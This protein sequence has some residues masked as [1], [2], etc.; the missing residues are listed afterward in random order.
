MPRKAK[1]TAEDYTRDE[2][3]ARAER[4]GIKYRSRMNKDQLFK[5]LGLGKTKKK[6]AAKK[7]A[8]KKKAAAVKTKA[9]KRKSTA[10]KPAKKATVKSTKRA[11]VRKAVT[12]K[13]AAPAKSKAPARKKAP[14]KA[15]VKATAERRAP[16]ASAKP[17]ATAKKRAK[18]AA[19]LEPVSAEPKSLPSSSV[20]P[21]PAMQAAAAAYVDRGPKLPD[22]YGDDRV[23]ALVRDPR[24]IFTYWELGGGGYE[25]ARD[26]LGSDMAGA[27]WVLRL[28]KVVGERFFD[29]PIDPATGNWYLHVEPSERYQ[30]KI[31]IVLPSGVFRELAASTEIVTP[32]ERVSDVVDEE[33]MLVREEFDRLIEQI[34]SVRA[35]GG[36]GSSEILHRLSNIPRRM[37]LFSGSIT[38]PRGGR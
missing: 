10:K 9:A 20:V 34:L 15:K 22:G 26:E 13:K 31:G 1:R 11:T 28:V 16:G 30:V 23:V 17:K 33:W 2:L 29:V 25:R 12:R 32:A 3:Y 14:V 37:E 35:P 5:A 27:V 4:K 7:A 36:I 19:K 21:P 38:S 6:A 24:C 8:P 18:P